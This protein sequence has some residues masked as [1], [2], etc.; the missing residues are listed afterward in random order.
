MKEK[1]MSTQI[2]NFRLFLEGLKR[3][4]VIGLATAILALTAYVA[5]D[6]IV[7]NVLPSSVEISI[8]ACDPSLFVAR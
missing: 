4:R 8:S 1:T 7:R 2:F 3:L 6:W 5:G